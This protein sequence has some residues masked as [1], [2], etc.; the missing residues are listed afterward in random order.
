MVEMLQ[1]LN[2][3]L[4]EECLCSR[5]TMACGEV[6]HLFLATERPEK[7]GRLIRENVSLPE[8]IGM[9]R[10]EKCGFIAGGYE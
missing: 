4:R 2:A 1:Y 7:T 3:V 6:E 9:F 10:D 5:D 8:L